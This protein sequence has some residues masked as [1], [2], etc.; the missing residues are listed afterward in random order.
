MRNKS[1][2]NNKKWIRAQNWGAKP[3]SDSSTQQNSE[4]HW[5]FWLVLLAT[6]KSLKVLQQGFLFV[7]IFSFHLRF[8]NFS[9]VLCFFLWFKINYWQNWTWK[10]LLLLYRITT[11]DENIKGNKLLHAILCTWKHFGQVQWTHLTLAF[12]NQPA[13]PPLLHNFDFSTE[14]LFS[15]KVYMKI[16]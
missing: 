7:L 10:F 2:N 5:H 8:F 9:L 3:T 13:I 16:L 4:S 14:S 6:T 11:L 1:K 12:R 15:F